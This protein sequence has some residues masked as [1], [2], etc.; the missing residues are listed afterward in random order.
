MMSGTPVFSISLVRYS[1]SEAVV[2]SPT[3]AFLSAPG[4]TI[5]VT[6]S[7]ANTTNVPQGTYD[8][9]ISRTDTGASLAFGYITIAP[10]PGTTAVDL[11]T[12]PFARA[13]LSDFAM[14]DAQIQFLPYAIT[15]ASAAV[16]RWCG[17]RDFIQK[18]YVEEYQIALDGTIMLRQP[19]N[20]VTRIQG[21]PSTVLTIQN[22]SANV[23]EAWV[24]G[25]YTGDQSIGLTLAGL[26]C[27]RVSSGTQT[28]SAVNFTAGMTISSLASAIT[29]LGNG[30]I[31]IADSIY[32]LYPVTELINLQLPRGATSGGGATYDV[33]TEDLGSDAKIDPQGTGLIWLGRQYKGTGIKWGPDYMEFDAPLIT[34][35]R[36]R[37]SYNAGFATIPMVVQK[38]VA[39]VAKVV[40]ATLSL[41]PTLQSESAEKY[42][43]VAREAVPLLP[44]SVRQG[45]SLY[46]LSHA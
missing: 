26:N 37:V 31:G 9:V 38:S 21:S 32:G 15:I 27:T 8:V 11:I 16:Q 33:Y 34:A 23:Q 18:N 19:P 10:S 5:N 13:A 24:A 1:A 6:Y 7:A 46:R 4:G 22:T 36:V 25:N 12:I 20:W 43:Y 2:F 29:A 30:W 28:T 35:G 44:S 17:D 42:A 45:L 41:D 3:V 40:V 39:S 14:S